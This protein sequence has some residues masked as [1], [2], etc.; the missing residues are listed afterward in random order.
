MDGSMRT[1]TRTAKIGGSSAPV[2]RVKR[3]GLFPPRSASN[4]RSAALTRSVASPLSQPVDL[5][6]SEPGESAGAAALVA[7]SSDSV[8]PAEIASASP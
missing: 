8:G 6:S 4:A 7:A 1:L 2:D 5:L 3:G